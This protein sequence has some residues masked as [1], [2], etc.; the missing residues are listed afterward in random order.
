MAGRGRGWRPG[1]T[2]VDTSFEVADRPAAAGHR[3][4]ATTSCSKWHIP[5][6]I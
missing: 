5:A 1:A 2:A 3:K 6:W 4:C